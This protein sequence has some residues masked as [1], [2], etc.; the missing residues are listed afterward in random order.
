MQ[1]LE[2]QLDR[3]AEFGEQLAEKGLPLA[4][5]DFEETEALRARVERLKELCANRDQYRPKEW[6]VHMR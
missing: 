4:D 3:M 2:A 6:L 1:R 5:S